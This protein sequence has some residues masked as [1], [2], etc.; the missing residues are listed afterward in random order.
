MGDDPCRVWLA[1]NRIDTTGEAILM[2]TAL[3]MAIVVMAVTI[4]WLEIKL[5]RGW[6]AMKA[7]VQQVI[8]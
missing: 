2:K 7:Q 6:D 3:T 8:E 4:G 5:M 1:G